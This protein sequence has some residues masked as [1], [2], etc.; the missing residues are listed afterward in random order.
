MQQD[1]KPATA[2]LVVRIVNPWPF[3]SLQAI[4]AQH[5]M[6]CSKATRVAQLSHYTRSGLLREYI[7][8][9]GRRLGFRVH[10]P[11]GAVK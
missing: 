8:W 3:K 4:T 5:K 7:L 11:G 2:L 9:C 6:L 1:P 10:Q